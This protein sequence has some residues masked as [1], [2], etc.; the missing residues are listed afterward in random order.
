LITDPP[1]ELG[2]WNT[3]PETTYPSLSAMLRATA[4]TIVRFDN[5]ARFEITKSSVVPSSYWTR[6]Y[7]PTFATAFAQACRAIVSPIRIR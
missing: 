7:A 6:K 3:D 5:V 2:A 1:L 4:P